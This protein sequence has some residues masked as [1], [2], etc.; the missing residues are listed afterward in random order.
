MRTAVSSPRPIALAPVQEPANSRVQ[1]I[2]DRWIADATTGMPGPW[3]ESVLADVPSA[4]DFS[5]HVWRALSGS[6]LPSGR[7]QGA[8][9]FRIL[10]LVAGGLALGLLIAAG[11]VWSVSGV[12]AASL[13]GA[14]LAQVFVLIAFLVAARRRRRATGDQRARTT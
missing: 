5:A 2:R 8:A 3:K 14:A 11:A 1:A 10:G 13:A 7:D 9:T 6:T 4:A 12:A